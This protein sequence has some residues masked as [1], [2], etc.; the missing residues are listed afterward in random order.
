M[1]IAQ[2]TYSAQL[3]YVA[4][5]KV[6]LMYTIENNMPRF[7]QKRVHVKKAVIKPDDGR[8]CTEKVC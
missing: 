2:C 5:C 3:L 8:K 1:N 6:E 7:L 4:V